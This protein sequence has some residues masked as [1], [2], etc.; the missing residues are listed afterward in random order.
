MRKFVRKHWKAFQAS[1]DADETAEVGSNPRATIAAAASQ[2]GLLAA[3]AYAPVVSTHAQ[4]RHPGVAILLTC[5][6]GLLT[7]TAGRFRCRGPIGTPATL[8][9]NACWAAALGYAAVNTTGG[10]SIALAVVQAVVLL[11][12]TTQCYSL[13]LPLALVLTVPA[14][15][16]L[17]LFPASDA[18]KVIMVATQAMALLMAHVTGRRRA[19]L[20]RK[21]QLE[22]ALGASAKLVDD[23]MQ[24]A[25]SSTLLNL[26]HFLHELRNYQTAVATNLHYLEATCALG[27]PARAALSEACAAQDAQAKLVRSTIDELRKKGRPQQ[28]TFLL[29][30]ALQQF[31]ERGRDFCVTVDAEPIPIALTGNPEHLSLVL[32]NLIRN[33]RQ[34]GATQVYLE[35][36]MSPCGRAV[37]LLIH[38]DGPGIPESRR[39][40]LFQPFGESTKPNGNG[41]GLYLCQRYAELFGGTLTLADGPLGGA[42]FV[43]QLPA[44]ILATSGS[45]PIVSSQEQAT[46]TA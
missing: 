2:S 34:A 36:R 7:L 42:G 33:A 46:V 44:V 22:H 15:G 17:V 41:L 43:L 32:T 19:L 45:R 25:L 5:V 35:A 37:R 24:A 12:F 30:D 16:M 38:D 18:V 31:A 3:I 1:Y 13:T 39:S 20:A 28:T 11:G 8:L 14:F 6:G 4:F 21:R 29:S 10:I 9:D 23:S 26:G 40:G 27:D